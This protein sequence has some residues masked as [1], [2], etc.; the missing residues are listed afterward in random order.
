[1]RCTK[2]HAVLALYC[3][4]LSYICLKA[5]LNILLHMVVTCGAT[6]SARNIRWYGTT[7]NINVGGHV[8]SYDVAVCWSTPSNASIHINMK[9]RIYPNAKIAK[10]IISSIK[11]YIDMPT[12]AHTYMIHI[13]MNI[14]IYPKAKLQNEIFHR[15]RFIYIRLQR[16]MHTY[17]LAHEPYILVHVYLYMS[18]YT[19]PYLVFVHCTGLCPYTHNPNVII[20]CS[21]SDTHTVDCM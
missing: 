16:H 19:Y 9:I 18:H 17:S 15:L 12:K 13:K 4:T 20:F 10:L 11:M 7:W 5:W 14:H 6:V 2:G 21:S 3:H 1:M 8:G